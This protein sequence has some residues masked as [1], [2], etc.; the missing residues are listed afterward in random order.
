MKLERYIRIKLAS[1]GSVLPHINLL[2]SG[3]LGAITLTKSWNEISL[4]VGWT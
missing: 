1:N 4:N 2:F 3:I